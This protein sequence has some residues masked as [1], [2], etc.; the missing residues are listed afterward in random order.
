MAKQTEMQNLQIDKTSFFT[1]NF[2]L[3]I[4]AISLHL[5]AKPAFAENMC[6]QPDWQ[7]IVKKNESFERIYQK[8]LVSHR[9]V[10]ALAKYNNHAPTKKLQPG[11]VLN[12]PVGMIKKIPTT[13]Q[14]LVVTGDVALT[15]SAS[16]NKIIAESANNK[17]LP[18]AS[19]NKKKLTTSDILVAGA[20]V[21]TGNNSLAK[22]QFSDGS[23]TNVQPNSM[24]IIQDSYR[25]IGRG[26][27]VILLKLSKGRTEIAANPSHSVINSMQI[28]TPSAVAA[29]RGTEFRVGAEQEIALQETLGGQVAFS[30][31]GQEVLVEKGFGSLVEK[32][33][34]PS[35]PIVLP[36]APDV[37]AFT[38]VVDDIPVQFNLVLQADAVAWVSQLALD[39]EFTKILNQQTVLSPTTKAEQALLSLGD[40]AD[41]QY[42]LKL[43][44]E[45]EHGLQ[46]SDAIHTFIVSAR[47]LPPKLVTPLDEAIIDDKPNLLTPI[48]LSWRAVPSANNYIVQISKDA[49]FEDK[50]FER[51]TSYNQLQL[52]SSFN[53]APPNT[54]FYWRVAVLS[55][56]KTH[57]F[58][59]IRSFTR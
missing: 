59:K 14:V 3:S 34:A 38:P 40:L 6:Q 50:V 35:L 44:A 16:I 48:D 41:G 49:N 18:P 8:Y 46:G 33:K 27:E 20:T 51:I 53:G 5:L 11:Q 47:P 26:G 25:Y 36:V 2:F 22:I 12:I 57:K 45:E 24:L 9:N 4:L 13:A 42:Y 54:T 43:R 15:H 32:D 1:L 17:A 55:Q 37:S 7:Y 29:V 39:A 58:S 30:A 56:G 21:Q 31:N 19:T 52:Q 28:Q 23:I 10:E